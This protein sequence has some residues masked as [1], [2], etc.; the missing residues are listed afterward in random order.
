MIAAGKDAGSTVILPAVNHLPLLLLCPEETSLKFIDTHCHYDFPP[1]EHHEAAEL[2]RASQAGVEKIIVPAV[3]SA[4]FSAVMALAGRYQPLYAALGLHPVW[5]EQHCDDDIDQLQQ[6]LQQQPAKLVAL[7]E[8]GLDYFTPQLAAY[9][10]QQ[11]SRLKAQLSLAKRYD[12]PVILHSRRTHDLLAGLLRQAK[13]PA[14]GVI[15]GFSGSLSQAMAFVKLGYRIGVGG[16]ITYPRAAKTRNTIAAL[17]LHALVLETDAPDMP[18][19]GFQGQPN[20]PEQIAAVWRVLTEL[21][22][23]PAEQIAQTLWNNSLRLFPRLAAS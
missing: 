16:T 2:K 14:S 20:R 1:F 15:H 19:H 3:S 10:E 12:L 5:T 23:E 18:L 17:P 6:W 8:T 7:G 11:I 22:S 21:R 13:L 9:S 4:R